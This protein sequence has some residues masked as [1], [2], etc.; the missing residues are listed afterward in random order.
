MVSTT[1]TQP[2]VLSASTLIGTNVK[3][4]EGEDLGKIEEIMIDVDYGYVAYAVL[5]FGG[6]L[7][8]GGKLFAIPWKALRQDSEEKEFVLNAD[9]DV[10]KNAP[11]FDKDNWPQISDRSWA[12][13]VYRHY[14]IEPYW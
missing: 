4:V 10:L 8:I 3:N 14:K 7:G 13:T 1:H 6:V 5:S 9:K 11:G 12:T 2:F